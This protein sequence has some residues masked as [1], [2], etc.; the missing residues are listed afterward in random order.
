MD[1]PPRT[2]LLETDRVY[3][4]DWIRASYAVIVQTCLYAGLGQSDADDVAQDLWVWLLR[5]GIPATIAATPWLRAAARNY[6]MRFRRRSHHRNVREGRPLQTVAEPQARPLL[7]SLEAKELLDQVAATLPDTEHRML[8]LIRNG[9]SFADAARLLEIPAGSR[10]F[11]KSRIIDSARR[12]LRA[13]GVN[14]VNRV[15]RDEQ[16]TRNTRL[17]PICPSAGSA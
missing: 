1:A 17:T 4:D 5:A 12:E 9:H 10:A 13:R 3:P 14:R 2:L 7:P 6:V 11:H 16:N 15:L 8:A